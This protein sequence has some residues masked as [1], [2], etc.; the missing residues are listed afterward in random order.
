ML[1]PP[2]PAVRRNSYAE[3]LRQLLRETI[4]DFRASAARCRQSAENFCRPSVILKPSVT[5]MTCAATGVLY[6]V[7]AY[8]GL[9]AA[10]DT[11]ELACQEFDRLW[12]FGEDGER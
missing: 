7:A 5:P 6:Y 9:F 11:P 10:G 12:M 3:E 2:L 1:L 4:E 8:S